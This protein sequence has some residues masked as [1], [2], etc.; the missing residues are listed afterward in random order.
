V[1]PLICSVQCQRRTVAAASAEVL[2][3]RS[4]SC[5]TGLAAATSDPLLP[6]A[7]LPKAT[8]A[9][10]GA[11]AQLEP[12]WTSSGWRNLNRGQTLSD[13]WSDSFGLLDKKP[14][15]RGLR[16]DLMA[17]LSSLEDVVA[18]RQLDAVAEASALEPW[19]NWGAPDP[20]PGPL[21]SLAYDLE[22]GDS[23]G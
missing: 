17:G 5:L 21:A 15:R 11:L 20:G 4:D 13:D 2:R 3:S 14:H 19:S 1:P 7:P 22:N 6:L 9:S 12:R 23:G 16:R 18:R 10:A 8:P